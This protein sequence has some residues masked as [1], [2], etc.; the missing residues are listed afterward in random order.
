MAIE[1]N[2]L[3]IDTAAIQMKLA[4]NEICSVDLVAAYLEQIHQHSLKGALLRALISLGPVDS[5]LTQ[6][7]ALDDEQ[8]TSGPRSRFMA[9]LS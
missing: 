4:A 8:K 9:S 2:L 7:Q 6:A 5:A 3:D 1:I